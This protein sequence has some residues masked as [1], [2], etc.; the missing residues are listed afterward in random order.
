MSKSPGKLQD[1]YRIGKIRG[2]GMYL[3]LSLYNLVSLLFECIGPFG[4][5][6]NCK[7]RESG[8]QRV[9]KVL[10]KKLMNDSDKLTLMNEINVL[11]QIVS[12]FN[13]AH[14]SWLQDH[15]GILK[16]YEYFE[17]A[18]RFY[19]LTD[20]S[21]GTELYEEMHAK[22][23]FTERDSALILQQILACLSYCH[24]KGIV[25]R[26][27]KPENILIEKIK[28]QEN[29]VKILD[30][31]SAVRGTHRMKDKVGS[32]YYIAPEV[33]NKS[34]DNLCDVWSVGVIAYMMLCGEPPFNGSNDSQILGKVRE[35]HFNFERP[36]WASV[37]EN[38]K[39]FVSKLLTLSPDNRPNAEQALIHPWITELA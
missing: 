30:F 22:G 7:H 32:P 26:D 25:H 19:L 18:D 11:Y 29:Q 16:I 2:N 33:L 10:R 17:D 13:C 3:S 12:T 39:D 4:E 8:S 27:L 6:R 28:H 9:V 37:S 15:P 20:N 24:N 14:P 1:Y 23:Q 36:V 35:G 34:Y 21:K 5:V 31:G 38:A